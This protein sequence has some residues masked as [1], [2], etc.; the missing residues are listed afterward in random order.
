MHLL[1]SADSTQQ[2]LLSG[3]AGPTSYVSKQV[4]RLIVASTHMSHRLYRGVPHCASLSMHR[5]GRFAP[6]CC[7]PGSKV[8]ASLSGAAEF[9][10]AM[11]P[12]YSDEKVA[13]RDTRVWHGATE[14]GP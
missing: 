5:V 14:K 12:A 7:A 13:N 6:S 1:S 11:R 10:D 3:D 4:G 2:E 9:T 8:A